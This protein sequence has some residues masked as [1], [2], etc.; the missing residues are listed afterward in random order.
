MT[1]FSILTNGIDEIKKKGLARLL[2]ISTTAVAIGIGI[3][4]A[5]DKDTG[6]V[7]IWPY[8]LVFVVALLAFNAYQGMKK[9]QKALSSYRLSISDDG[10]ITREQSNLAP[11]SISAIEISEIIKNKN[12]SICIKGLTKTDVIYIPAQ[13]ERQEILE[14][15]LNQLHSI[16]VLT[17]KTP[18]QR[19]GWVLVVVSLCSTLGVFSSGN[20]LIVAVS[21]IALTGIM[22]YG[23]IE[24]RNNKNI[25]ERLRKRSWLFLIVL[26][27]AWFNILV[28]VFDV[29]LLTVLEP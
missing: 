27:A 3:S 15:R 25:D 6:S 26:L 19:F 29:N 24:L 10:V 13:I 16:T 28:K 21:G 4:M 9:L 8:Y 7:N 20:K 22:L 18:A 17:T 14:A 5:N 12:G 23:F 2:L 1:S 11:L